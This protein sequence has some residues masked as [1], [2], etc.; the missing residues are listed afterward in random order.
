VNYEDIWTNLGTHVCVADPFMSINKA[1]ANTSWL[2]VY[3]NPVVSDRFTITSKHSVKEIEIFSVIGKSVYKQEGKKG[4]QQVE[5]NSLDL[6]KGMYL[7]KVTSTNN[8]SAVKKI[9]IK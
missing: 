7:V 3:P 2:S 8:E 6:D 9:M 1:Q 4:Q 5:I